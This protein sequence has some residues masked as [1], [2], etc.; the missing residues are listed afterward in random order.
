MS[1]CEVFPEDRSCWIWAAVGAASKPRTVRSSVVRVDL[2]HEALH[3]SNCVQADAAK[4]PFPAA[5]FDVAI[6]N[7]S[8]EHFENLSASLAEIGRVMKPDGA[9]YIAV[10]DAGTFSDRL[11]RWLGRGGGHVNPFTSAREL[12][13]AIE[14]ATGLAHVATVTLCT[15]FCFL[16]SGNR[17]ARAPIR[18]WLLGGGTPAS[19]LLLHYGCRMFDRYLGTRLSVYGWALYFGKIEEPV[20][21]QAW[22]NVCIRCGSGHPCEGLHVRKVLWLPSYA[23]SGAPGK[24]NLFTDDQTTLSSDS[25]Q[26]DYLPPQSPCGLPWVTSSYAS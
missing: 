10:P 20:A 1:C 14:R 23:V 4:L 19:V 16:H 5:T 7:H 22:T 12:A 2:D 9:L 26:T 3:A 6:S 18:L 25:R 13:S 11:Y 8:L 15:S 24:R 21:R 17:R